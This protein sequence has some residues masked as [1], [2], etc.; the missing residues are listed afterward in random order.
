[1]Q[2]PSENSTQAPRPASV[3]KSAVFMSVA[4]LASRILGMFRDMVMA[5]FFPRMVSDAYVVA[6]RLP[7]LFRRVLGE[8]SLAASFIPLYVEAG[9]Q[10]ADDAKRFSS[11]VFTMLAVLTATLSV[12]GIVFMEP[13]ISKLVSGESYMQVEGKFELTVFL[14]RLMFAY[15]F[16]VT[17]YAFYMSLANAHK[18][19]FLPALAPAGFN[20]MT[21]VMAFLP[22][23]RMNGDQLA[24]G[25]ILGGVLQL[26][27]AAYPLIK[28]KVW[29]SF[30]FNWRESRVKEFFKIML[31]SMMGMSVA[32][33]LG[34]MN[35]YFASHLP[36][37]AHSYIYLADR[38][39]EFPQSLLSVS[40]GVALLPTL[41]EMWVQNRHAEFLETAQ[42][43][44]RLL[45]V[46]S[47]PAAVGLYV[48][49][50][51]IVRVIYGRGEFGENDILMTSQ[52]L[53]IYAFVLV[54]TGLH[55]VT[56]PCF[57]AIK[58]TWLPALN[59]TICIL[60]HFFVAD[61]A[62]HKFG[63]SG[64]VGATA[65]TGLLNLLLL[66][67]SYKFIFK[68][69][70]VVSFMK[71]VLWLTPALTVMGYVAPWVNGYLIGLFEHDFA[72]TVVKI[73]ALSV[74]IAV[75][76]VLFFGVNA[77]LRHPESSEVSR[78]ILGKIKKR[79]KISPRY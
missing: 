15:L 60:I 44:I 12:L 56:V 73:L 46:L 72:P 13:L 49:S 43:H 39:L 11:A 35:V 33:L 6:F 31:P 65:F 27:M 4:T 64:L 19:F 67:A 5:A 38:L 59:S 42:R 66:L 57:Y 18:V 25:V 24:T 52:V 58:N 9:A 34:V 40:L 54:V 61:W 23:W 8:G 48:L 71:S 75:A 16:L 30:N 68:E 21:I 70:G 63:L 32:Q 77:L 69:L 78:L 28:L 20:V 62:T 3:L 7:N 36:E 51:P 47:M 17:T 74:S 1:M 29:P 76:V 53:A 10:S 79:V 45:M 50:E 26:V 22:A 41:S 2:N 37:G 14:A 55:R